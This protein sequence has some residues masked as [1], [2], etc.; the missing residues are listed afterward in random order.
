MS[1]APDT[2]EVVDFGNVLDVPPDPLAEFW[3]AR[4]ELAHI[5]AFAR[6]RRAGPWATLGV[7]L[8]HGI[9]ATEPNVRLPPTVGRAASLNLFCALVG[10]SGGGKGAA[11]GAAAD[12]VTFVGPLGR[13]I[14]TE[15]LPVGS[16][17]GI[18]RT[19]LPSADGDR[20]TRALFSVPEVDTLAALGSRQGSTIMGELRKV[21]MGEQIG[22][23]N[24]NKATRTPV[25]AHSF[26]A[27]VVVGV[28]PLRAAALFNDADGGT[29][30]R[31]VWLPVSDPDAPD[32]RPETPQPL[33]V[34]VTEFAAEQ[35]DMPIPEVARATIDAHR[36][37]A[38]R[39]GAPNPLD[40]HTLLT[41]LKVAAA[42]AILAGRCHV[43][44]EDWTL[45][46]TVMRVSDMTRARA[47]DTIAD[48]AATDARSKAEFR[49]MLDG[50][51][52]D[53][54][55]DR[56]RTRTRRAILRCLDRRHGDVT[57]REFREVVDAK[58][59]HLLDDVL[60]ELESDGFIVS[61]EGPRRSRLF[62]L[63]D[64]GGEKDSECGGTLPS[65]ET[66]G[67]S[68]GD[69]SPGIP[70]DFSHFRHSPKRHT[71]EPGERGKH[72]G[73]ESPALT[74]M[75]DRGNHSLPSVKR[76][77][78]GDS[79]IDTILTL[80][81]QGLSVPKVAA[82]LNADGIKP[83]QA[84]QWSTRMVEKRIDRHKKKV[85]A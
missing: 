58:L 7:V 80:R 72:W 37:A 56:D 70:P 38:L 21:F 4:P 39:G 57:R 81:N 46:A 47:L 63:A 30:Q 9:A 79:L 33:K 59:R 44:E 53:R 34:Q 67:H 6:A 83:P 8:A 52:E 82:R 74:C 25:A 19:F 3:T 31:F 17:E 55:E 43:D 13:R 61:K 50:F 29:P 22:F 23:A 65:H 76:G 20:I 62:Q 78:A 60:T 77:N 16:G 75:N 35:V 54:R 42:L 84:E 27:A 40:S 12:A 32:E 69:D 14:E 85:N 41:R 10:A 71:R 66:A 36:L 68:G 11:E 45:S 64:R 5:H 73:T 51:S 24:A 2:G 26:R 15:Q 28:Q 48:K 18:A 1:T 49:A